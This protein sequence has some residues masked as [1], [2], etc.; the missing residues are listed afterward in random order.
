[1][2]SGLLPALIA[3]ASLALV[4]LAH[5]AVMCGPV[6]L[7]ARVRGGPHSVAA[8]YLGRLVTYTV[9]G[10]LAGSVARAALLSPWA[11]WAEAVLAWGFAAALVYSGFSLLFRARRPAGLLT[12]GKAPRANR[13]GRVL[14][15]L[16]DDALLLGM[17]TALLPCGALYS[18]LAAAALLGSPLA[19][20]SAMAAFAAVSGL[21][22]VGVAQLGALS[23]KRV[24]VQQIVGLALVASAFLFV[25]RPIPLLRAGDDVPA[26]H[27]PASGVR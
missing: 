20:A 21:A 15:R 25:Y 23:T 12:L 18:A 13:I 3:G 1:M 5:C 11:R 2:L 6:A 9:L 10:A 27:Q 19:G 26:C 8:Y 22:V 7:T 14:A 4:S 17:A 16:A 24:R